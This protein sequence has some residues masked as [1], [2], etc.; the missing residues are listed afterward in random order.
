MREVILNHRTIRKY[1]SDPIDPALLEKILI[2]G[3][4]ASTTGNMQVY[5]IIVTTDSS[6]KE[7]LW[8]AHFR[9]DMV[10]QA[11]VILTF[12]ADFHRFNLWCKLRNAEPGYD[13]FLSF[14]TASID[15]LLAA[16][17]VCIAAESYGLGI[18]YLGTTTYMAGSITEILGLPENV[19]PVT[20]VVL[21]YP[22]ENPGLTDRLP[23]NA[24]VH[25]EKYN[26]Y[27]PNQ[28]ED[29]YNEKENLAMTKELI[30]LNKTENLAQIFTDKRYTKKDNVDF[31]KSFLELIKNQKF[32]NNF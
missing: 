13:N 3:T 18:C 15:A 7:K 10:K 1:K 32:M 4:R 20:T 11:P 23:L 31:S 5:S 9:Q 17:N 29:Y 14:Y 28:I 12:C 27:T 8:T 25:S 30:Q 6:I 21:G 19:V 16:Q 22:D 24:V 26:A 2:A